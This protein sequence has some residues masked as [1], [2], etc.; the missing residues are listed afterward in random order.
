MPE[1]IDHYGHVN[2]VAYIAQ[3]EQ[4][5]WS[6]SNALG[7]SIDN[8]RSLDRAMVVQSHNVR[9]ILP[10]HLN[11]KVL[12][13]TWVTQIKKRLTLKRKFQYIC[14][15]R[16]K[17]VF[18]AETTFVSVALTSGRPAR[19]PLELYDLYNSACIGEET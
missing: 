18:E 8:F 13:A 2:N 5:A 16:E 14:E 11:N 9:Y 12:C 10:C 3:I 6:H 15:T 17:I 7:I 19:M 4:V 1:H